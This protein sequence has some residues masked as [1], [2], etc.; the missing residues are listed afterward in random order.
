MAQIRHSLQLTVKAATLS[1]C[2]LA[3]PSRLLAG[4]RPLVPRSSLG[5]ACALTRSGV[6]LGSKTRRVVE[7]CLFVRRE[8]DPSDFKRHGCAFDPF[9]QFGAP[10]EIRTPDPLVRSS[11]YRRNVILLKLQ[12]FDS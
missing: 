11:P 1:C 10:G 12:V 3:R 2:N 9:L 6:Q 8:F 4:Y 7:L 5:T